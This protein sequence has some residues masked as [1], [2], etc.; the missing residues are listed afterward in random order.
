METR[1]KNLTAFEEIRDHMIGA[2]GSP[3][4]QE[5][6]RGYELFKMGVTIC[7]VRL[8]K[9]MSEKQLAQKCGVKKALINKIEMQAENCKISDLRNVIEKGLGGR[10]QLLIQ[11]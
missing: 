7:Q 10:F 4:R 3:E 5:Y 2:E 6:E 1:D 9:G 11:V 8:D